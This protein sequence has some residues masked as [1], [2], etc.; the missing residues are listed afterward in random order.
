MVGDLL[1]DFKGGQKRC[2]VKK[3]KM[4]LSQKKDGAG[5]LPHSLEC[6]WRALS[7]ATGG[8]KLNYSKTSAALKEHGLY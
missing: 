5:F 8:Q 3:I 2:K 4:Q 7:A 1:S 6:C